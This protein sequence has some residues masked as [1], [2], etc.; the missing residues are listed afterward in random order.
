MPQRV[1]QFLAVW[2]AGA[3]LGLR[4]CRGHQIHLG[5]ALPEVAQ[6]FTQSEIGQPRIDDHRLGSRVFGMSPGL[7]AAF[8]FA[9]LPAQA[10]KQLRKPLAEAAVGARHQRGARP[11]ARIDRKNRNGKGLHDCLLKGLN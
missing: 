1:K 8:G 6:K 11:D 9:N 3:L 5:K 10:A 2:T 4:P 7:G